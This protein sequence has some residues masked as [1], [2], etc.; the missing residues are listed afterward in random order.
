MMLDCP[1]FT[2][3]PYPTLHTCYIHRPD[4]LGQAHDICL[5]NAEAVQGET[6]LD[7]AAAR[8]AEQCSCD[9]TFII[10]ASLATSASGESGLESGVCEASFYVQQPLLIGQEGPLFAAGFCCLFAPGA[11]CA[12]GG[13]GASSAASMAAAQAS[14]ICT[15]IQAA[16]ITLLGLDLSALCGDVEI[17]VGTAGAPAPRPAPS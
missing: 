6:N 13:A 17:D 15:N 5:F 7:D 4:L 9:A 16:G 3:P 8:T 10:E 1:A 14:S 12:D 2:L 11:A